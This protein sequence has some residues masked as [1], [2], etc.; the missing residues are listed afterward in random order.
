MKEI[1]EKNYNPGRLMSRLH[2]MQAWQ[3]GSVQKACIKVFLRCQA[4]IMF[5]L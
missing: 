4:R 1:Y 5:S 2:S 3:P